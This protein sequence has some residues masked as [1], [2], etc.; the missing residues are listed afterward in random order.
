MIS[1]PFFKQLSSKDCGP[2]CL[3]MVAEYYGRHYNIDGLRQIAGYCKEGTSL[4][5]INEAAEKIGFRTRAV[6]LTS[7]QL[8]NDAHL[9]CIL[10]WDQKHFVVL[11]SVDRPFFSKTVALLVADPAKRLITYSKEALLQHW[12]TT[13]N[14]DQN[15]VGT[16]LLLEPTP[17]FFEQKGDKSL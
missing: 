8:I 12:E 10:H 14:D 4:L 17:D 15:P 5:G 9:P 16:V 11:A 2:T 13:V 3:R 6:Q 7:E 1:F